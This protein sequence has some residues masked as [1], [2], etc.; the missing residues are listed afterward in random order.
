MT[1]KEIPVRSRTGGW[2]RVVVPGL[3]LVVLVSVGAVVQRDDPRTSE[4]TSAAMANG[5]FA[6]PAVGAQF[7]GT[8]AELSDSDQD[9][10]L[11]ALVDSGVRWVR[12]DIAWSMIQ[13]KPGRYDTAWGVPK[14][15]RVLAKAHSRGLRVLGMFWSTPR[16]ANGAAGKRVLPAD[17]ADYASALRFAAA[18][19]RAEV[20]AWEVWNEP[21]SAEFLRPP[22]PAAYVRLLRAAYP[23][24]KAADV[25]AQ[26]VFGGLRY[27]DTRWI[28]RAYGHGARGAFDVMAVH[29]YQ[30]RAVLPPE[31]PPWRNVERLTHTRELIATMA[32]HGDAGAPIWFTEFGWSAHPNPPGTPVWARGVSEQT[33]ADY[34]RRTLVMVRLVY[35][36]VKNVFWYTSRDLVTGK[37]HQDHRGLLRRDFTSRPALT[38]VRCYVEGCPGP[39]AARRASGERGSR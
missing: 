17:P 9:R 25:D 39:S 21:N 15:D 14:V 19:W 11:A 3:F 27:V 32:A 26:V 37:T 33:Q 8:W 38:V 2:R 34:L 28:T 13:P 35:P 24:V 18:R 29:P 5:P 30:G 20:S 16:W 1:T 23:A 36:Q 10:I 12:V 31:A 22:D 4:A 7:H 6:S